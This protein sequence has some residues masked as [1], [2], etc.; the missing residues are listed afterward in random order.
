MSEEQLSAE[1][2]ARPAPLH[3]PERNLRHPAALD[4]RRWI[5]LAILSGSLLLLM[6]GGLAV[7]AA[8]TT[9]ALIPRDLQPTE[10]H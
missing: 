8:A 4:P 9:W 5:V 7:A 2:P 3:H 1:P 6:A 10:N